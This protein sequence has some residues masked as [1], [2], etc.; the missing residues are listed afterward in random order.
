METNYT[1]YTFQGEVPTVRLHTDR[2]YREGFEKHSYENLTYNLLGETPLQWHEGLEIV[3]VKKGSAY[4][5]I[6]MRPHEVSEGDIAII[7][8]SQLHKTVVGSDEYIYDVLYL[9]HKLCLDWGFEIGGIF[10]ENRIRDVELGVIFDWLEREYW[11]KEPFYRTILN[12]C[13][14]QLLGLLTRRYTAQEQKPDSV[15]L[16]KLILVRQIM[17][18]ISRNYQS[19]Q[20]LVLLSREL[21]YSQYYLSHIFKEM[22]GISI[23]EYQMENRFQLAKKMLIREN[24][25]VSEIAASL[26]YNNPASFSAE[27][28]KRSGMT[29]LAYRDKKRP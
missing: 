25:S 8:S 12:A 29:P 1:L 26:G 2:L 18:Y 20:I 15:M 23:K 24:A 9:D 21:K 5:W 17:Q 13:C 7:N 14:M 3:R 28:K 11:A 4:I 6:D 19:Q 22:T 16:K 27:F 10:Y